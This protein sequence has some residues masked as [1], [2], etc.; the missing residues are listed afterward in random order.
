ME[1]NELIRLDARL[2]DVIDHAV[3]SAELANGH[4]FVVVAKQVDAE[5]LALLRP[6]CM[7]VVEMSPFDMSRGFLV[8]GAK[9]SAGALR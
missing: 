5:V 2:L 4:R 7:V 6:P 3:F 9:S 8:A 1:K